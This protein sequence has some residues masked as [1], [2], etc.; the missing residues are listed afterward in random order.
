MYHCTA[1]DVA[2]VY[3]VCT[4]RLCTS[5]KRTLFAYRLSRLVGSLAASK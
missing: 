2:D 5:I 4:P 3:A 1:I